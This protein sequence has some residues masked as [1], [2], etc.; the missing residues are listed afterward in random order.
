VGL[1]GLFNYSLLLKENIMLSAAQDV[2]SVP[3]DLAHVLNPMISDI[4]I[5]DTLYSVSQLIQ[6]IGAI[7]SQISGSGVVLPRFHM[8]CS[9][10]SSAIEYEC[11]QLAKAKPATG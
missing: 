11:L 1:Y 6:D 9:A 3:R 5:E 7:A 4:G 8:V 10:V 2:Q